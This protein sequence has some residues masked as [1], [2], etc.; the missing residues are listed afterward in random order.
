MNASTDRSAPAARLLV[1]KLVATAACLAA[2]AAPAAPA[3]EPD[4]E[5][6]YRLDAQSPLYEAG[7][8]KA[9]DL[10]DEVTLEAW[11]KADKMPGSG[12]RILDK[13]VAGTSDGYMLDTHPGNS[14]RMITLNGAVG[15]DAKLSEAAWTH[16]AGVYSASK[17]V[18]KLYVSGKE[19]ASKG[20]GKF[21]PLAKT[22]VPL[23]IGADP[24]GGNRFL[25]RIKRAAVYRRA[26]TAEEIAKRA[27]G[28]PAPDGVIGEWVLDAKPGKTIKPAA[29]ALALSVAGAAGA[30]AAADTVELTGEAPPPE[31]RLTLWYRQPAKVWTEANPLGNGRLGAMVFGGV[32]R[33]RLQLN[34][35]TLWA[36]GP[37]DPT[38]D[39]ALPALPRI[40]QLIFDGKYKEAHNLVGQKFLS[41]PLGQM[42]YQPVGDLLLAVPVEGPASDYRRD[43]DLETATARIQ[44]KAGGVTWTREVFASA[45]DQA[46]IVR[47]TADQPGR[48]AFTASMASPQKHA[49]EA[50]APDLL[51]L[52]GTSGDCQGVKGA[53][54][55]EARVKV[56]TEG[57]KAEAEGSTIKV[58]GADSATLL[59]VAATSYVNAK[60]VS[61]DP[62][63]RAQ[64]YLAD[65][66]A[67]AYEQL[68]KDHVADYQ[69][70][71]KRTALD[72][73]ITDAAKR[74]TNERIKTFA[75]GKD[76]QL[77]EMYFQFARYLLISCSRPGGQP[78]TLQGLWND[79]MNPPWSSKY[80]ININTEMN[81]WPVEAGNLSECHEPLLRMVGEL[82]EP[83]SRTAKRHYG[84][85]GWVCHHNTDLWRATG[86]IDGPHW[87]MW[88]SGGAWLC[89]H[90]WEH[91]AY[92]GDKEFLA[93]AY[94]VMKGAAEFYLDALV[95]EPKHKWLVTCP[96]VSPENGHPFGT[97]IC[98]GPTMDMQ[99][100]RDL[101]TQCM[102]ASEVLGTD[103]AFREQVAKTRERLAPMQVGAA[104]QLQ[105]WLEDW[106]LKAP[107]R[108]HRHVS[109]L[110]GLFPSEQITRRGTP[111][112]FDAARKTLELRGDGG[113]GWSLAW[114]VNFWARL[115]DGD[116]SYK[117]LATLLHP[118]RTFPNMFDAH[119]PF[120]I[121]GNFGGCSG[122]IQML[123]Q[124]REGEIV[125]LP[126]LP[127]AWPVGS[128]KGLRAKGAFE[129]DLAWK[130]GK[131]AE[132][133]IKSLRGN[134]AKVR[135][136][137]KVVEVK[138]EEGKSYRL[139]GELEA[140]H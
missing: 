67:R 16:V 87:G 82:V 45:P 23:R 132:A 115:E 11:V 95:E 66:G 108:Q 128:V 35:G 100:I 43:L 140:G 118:E 85:K 27:E 127:S 32:G 63:A 6:G 99:I 47:L 1:A 4:A 30:A 8:D 19:V 135:Y 10:T 20:D 72:I 77:A 56:R 5:A 49:V 7:P 59:V 2:P 38:H 129:V 62:A 124:C 44:Y 88:P 81:Y 41:R 12:G 37:Y 116:H 92:T 54:T 75:D 74:P 48:V 107:E 91:Y 90:L 51:V 22:A 14:L 61:G 58:T 36:G 134:P 29:G 60:D 121:D 68:K 65:I 105:E 112:L 94:P 24:A 52:R 103:A 46:I 106:D 136:G 109:H 69:K 139:N 119:P 102:A 96:S 28:G 114:K 86:P 89:T 57:G 111:K 55:Y 50:A 98:A 101:F 17:K 117:M 40:R 21:P 123:L 79:L 93:T 73:G 25:G 64:K 34:E 18:Q 113:T 70:L 9:L 33:E 42:S 126:A 3:A 120:Q 137:A 125:L 110:Y 131:L 76:P 53:L 80:T 26:L 78:A 83:G 97:S 84:A 13:S 133:V 130:D 122:V 138:T 39:D 31:G 71:F 15:F 104:G